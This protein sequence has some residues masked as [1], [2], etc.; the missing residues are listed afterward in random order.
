M[1]GQS[2]KIGDPGHKAFNFPNRLDDVDL[3]QLEGGRSRFELDSWDPAY[4]QLTLASDGKAQTL[5]AD[6][7]EGFFLYSTY[8]FSSEIQ[9]GNSAAM[10]L[11]VNLISLQTSERKGEIG[12]GCKSDNVEYGYQSSN[13]TFSN[14]G[15]D[16]APRNC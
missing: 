6:H 10:R 2:L 8:P 1:E 11:L 13:G 16:G 3:Q 9:I 14:F 12:Q 5:L 7:G 15:C 4:Q